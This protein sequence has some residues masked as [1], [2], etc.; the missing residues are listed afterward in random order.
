LGPFCKLQKL[1]VKEG[2]GSGEVAGTAREEWE[3]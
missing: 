2:E 3:D 1:K